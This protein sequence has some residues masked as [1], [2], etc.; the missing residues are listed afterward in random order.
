[1]FEVSIS[2]EAINRGKEVSKFFKNYGVETYGVSVGKNNES[3]IIEDYIFPELNKILIINPS[4]NTRKDILKVKQGLK[5][6]DEKIFKRSKISSYDGKSFTAVKF[7]EI[8][9]EEWEVLTAVE[10]G[11][12]STSPTDR[13][14]EKVE[15]E[16][17]LGPAH[18]HPMKTQKVTPSPNDFNSLSFYLDKTDGYILET[19]FDRDGE[20]H[21]FG[22]PHSNLTSLNDQD[23]VPNY[24]LNN[25]IKEHYKDFSLKFENENFQT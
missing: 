14:F 10:N 18:I 21:L 11:R 6:K 16:N 2:E 8:L 17:I 9:D 3:K 1:M 25:W 13:F 7:E 24:F 22:F 15:D 4:E 5:E 23:F 12:Y 20:I 19:I